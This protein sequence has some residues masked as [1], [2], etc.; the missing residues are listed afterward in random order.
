[1][2]RES[3]TTTA[4][5]MKKVKCGKLDQLFVKASEAG[6]YSYIHAVLTFDACVD[7]TFIKKRMEAMIKF[8]RYRSYLDNDG[9]WK[10]VPTTIDG[11]TT[12]TDCGGA[13]AADDAYLKQYVCD[14]ALTPF[15]AK[16]SPW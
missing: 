8:S 6:S 11:H 16:K 15:A 14:V 13:A 10:E 4:A 7:D 3:N 5:P 2:V 9:Y 1:M 12:I